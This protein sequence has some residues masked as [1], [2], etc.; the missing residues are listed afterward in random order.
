[1]VRRAEL[2]MAYGDPNTLITVPQAIFKL[3]YYV[4]SQKGT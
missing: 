3:I 4:G 2:Y 1:M